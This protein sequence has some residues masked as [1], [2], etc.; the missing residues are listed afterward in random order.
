MTSR[1]SAPHALSSDIQVDQADSRVNRRRN[2]A[3]VAAPALRRLADVRDFESTACSRYF[4]RGRATTAPDLG[5]PARELQRYL[6][7]G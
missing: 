5:T 3:A 4:S 6:W 7:S 2:I 1:R